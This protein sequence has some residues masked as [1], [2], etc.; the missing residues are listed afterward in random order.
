MRS[1]PARQITDPLLLAQKVTEY[2]VIAAQIKAISEKE[3][4]AA[5]SAA[6]AAAA[7]AKIEYEKK[8]AEEIAKAAAEKAAH[9]AELKKIMVDLRIGNAN[10][11]D[12]FDAFIN[13]SGVG[14]NK[15]ALIAQFKKFQEEGSHKG[16]PISPFEYALIQS[17]TG[18]GHSTINKELRNP[19]WS[20]RTLVFAKAVNNGLKKLPTYTKE[21]RRGTSL[22]L[23]DQQKYATAGNIVEELAFMST[24]KTHP[25]SGNTQ[26]YVKGT[27]GRDIASL[28]HHKGEAE[29]LYPA[30]TFFKI[31]KVEGKPGGHM[32]VWMTE[33][34]A[35]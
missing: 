11:A 33:V 35:F 23:A 18:S 9:E 10:D 31:D 20:P 2:K 26:W 15:Q 27:S 28:S 29:V 30:R 14:G 24:S 8:H 5:K 13:L 16:Y 22:P 4:S 34:E 21:T 12:V 1:T 7:Q 32:T 19:S 17:Y 6:Q 3:Q 25:W